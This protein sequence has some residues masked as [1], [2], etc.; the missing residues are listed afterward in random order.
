LACEHVFDCHPDSLLGFGLVRGVAM[1]GRWAA[2]QSFLSLPK[3]G[4]GIERIVLVP[5]HVTSTD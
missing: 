4:L 1:L 3:D 2:S 5:L